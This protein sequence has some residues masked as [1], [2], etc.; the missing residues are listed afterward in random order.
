[1]AAPCRRHAA[2]WI[3]M[4]RSSFWGFPRPIATVVSEEHGNCVTAADIKV[5]GKTRNV[6]TAET[7][8]KGHFKG[9]ES[10]ASLLRRS[11]LVQM[12]PSKDKI[13]IGKIFPHSALA[14]RKNR[15]R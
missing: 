5:E 6:Q 4:F 7:G 3:C 9:T 15:R 1:M 2:K 13:A 12:G 8:D 11:P 14:K 10:F